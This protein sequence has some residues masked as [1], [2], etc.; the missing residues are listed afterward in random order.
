MTSNDQHGP[1]GHGPPPSA[2]VAKV[3]D[4]FFGEGPAPHDPKVAEQ[5]KAAIE[6]RKPSWRQAQENS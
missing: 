2:E 6:K 1:D 4:K 5:A 3:R